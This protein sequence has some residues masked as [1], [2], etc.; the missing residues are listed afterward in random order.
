MKT[1]PDKSKAVIF[2]IARMK[3]P[4]NYSLLDD[5]TPEASNCK[6]LGIII[7]SYLS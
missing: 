3:V 5:E 4:L 6:Y 2:T 7:R 1:N